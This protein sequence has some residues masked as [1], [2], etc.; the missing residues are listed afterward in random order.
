[1]RKNKIIVEETEEKCYINRS[2]RHL[3]WHRR[4]EIRH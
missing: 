2:I 4:T 1:M 3:L